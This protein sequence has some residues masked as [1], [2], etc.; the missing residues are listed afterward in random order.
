MIDIHN[1][2]I[3]GLDDGAKTLEDSIEMLKYA[4]NNGITTIITTPH[5]KKDKY[6]YCLEQIENNYDIL[7]ACL[8]KQNI[9]IQLYLGNEAYLD[10]YLLQ[11]LI[12]KQCKTLAGSRYCLI[13][14]YYDTPFMGLKNIL[15]DII[16]NGY[17]PII[18]HCE[19][20]IIDKKDTNKIFEL[21]KMGCYLQINANV[22]SSSKKIWLRKWLIENLENR[23]ISF[24][25]TD[26]HN[27]LTRP[28]DLMTAYN[29][30]KK[31]LG[32]FTANEIFIKN[33]QKVI[34]NE[35]V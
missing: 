13:E 23:L 32:I 25:S 18:A 3:F 31:K 29:L 34:L 33:P 9:P 2:F 30:V 7:L 4:Y 27:T 15:F 19:R 1:H 21:K 24:V 20:L 5:Y 10:E 28:P 11:D 6:V 16:S 26:A 35:V 22:L 14:I 17:I 12:T 8:D